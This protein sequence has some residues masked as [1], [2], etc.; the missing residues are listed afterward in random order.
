M[1]TNKNEAKTSVI[2][3][4]CYCKFKFNSAKWDSNQKWNNKTLQ[5]ECK[6]YHKCKNDY[7]WN[8]NICTCESSKYSQII[9]HTS[10]IPCDKAIYVMDILS[11]KMT[12][13]IAK[14]TASINCRNKKVRYK[15]DRSILHTVLVAITLL[16]LINIISHYHPKQ[17][18]KKVLT[19]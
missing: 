3:I 9:A 17:N 11:T 14:S 6:N 12:N 7:R 18:N 16:L 15:I 19:H 8:P 2:H 13:T 10:V 5:C 4:L 1:L